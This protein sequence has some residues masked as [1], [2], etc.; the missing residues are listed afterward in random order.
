M[1]EVHVGASD[2]TKD[3]NNFISR[4]GINLNGNF[5]GRTERTAYGAAI[6]YC[7][8]QLRR[9]GDTQ[10]NTQISTRFKAYK[11]MLTNK[12]EAEDAAI[13]LAQGLYEEL[14]EFIESDKFNKADPKMRENIIGLQ[15]E[16]FSRLKQTKILGNKDTSTSAEIPVT[17][18]PTSQAFRAR[19]SVLIKAIN[20]A[21]KFAGKSCPADIGSAEDEEEGP[22][23]G[24][25]GSNPFTEQYVNTDARYET[26]H[27]PGS[28]P[29]R[30]PSTRR[31]G[32]STPPAVGTT[33][34]I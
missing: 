13:P 11:Q 32:E 24:E 34:F 9:E 1:V 16:L 8:I 28:K 21:P 31:P 14:T 4:P 15:S 19:E 18:N 12:C 2:V 26:H 30:A 22:V 5:E 10:G 6:N 7:E 17:Y 33:H 25:V 29:L 23:A 27:K 20:V 3:F